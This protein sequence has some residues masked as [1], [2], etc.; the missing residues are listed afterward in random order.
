MDGNRPL[1]P[2]GERASARAGRSI[3]EL[4]LPE[5]RVVCSPKL[6]A[7]QTAAILA[8]TIGT[9]EPQELACLLGGLDPDQILAGLGPANGAGTLIAVG[10]EPDMGRLLARL[11]DPAWSGAIPFPTAG[12]A[13]IEIGALPP[14]RA[15][16]L[17][18]FADPRALST[19]RESSARAS[20]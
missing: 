4:G 8:S 5:P 2:A 3:A 1:T 9:G 10:H 14:P 18:L 15:G 13:W 11:I 12:V 7:R 17:R 16:R 19:S 6:R 20:S